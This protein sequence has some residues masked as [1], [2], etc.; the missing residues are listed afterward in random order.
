MK[1][2]DFLKAGLASVSLAGCNSNWADSPIHQ[3][4]GIAPTVVPMYRL[5]Y[6]SKSKHL[7][8]GSE[9]EYNVLAS[10]GWRREN[11]SFY[12]YNNP[13]TVENQATVAWYRLYN[14]Y[15]GRHHWTTSLTEYEILGTIGWKQEG[16]TAYMLTAQ[17]SNS[18]P[19]FRLYNPNN[20]AHHWT[21]DT[22]EKDVLVSLGWKDEGIIGYVFAAAPDTKARPNILFVYTDDQRSDSLG[23]MG[24]STIQTP[25]LDDYASKGT[26]FNNSYITSS[27]CAISRACS[28]T[29]QYASKHGVDDFHKT[30]SDSQLDNS[31]PQI[32]R[33]NGYYVGFIGKWGI[34]DSITKTATAARVFDYWGGFSHQGSYWH[35]ADCRYVNHDGITDKTNNTC[36]C[37]ADSRGETGPRN[38]IG[39][40]NLVDPIHL[41]TDV[42]PAKVSD[43]LTTRN[44]DQPFCLNLYMKGPHSP[45]TDIPP[46]MESLY[47]GDVPIARTASPEF[48]DNLPSFIDNALGRSTG[49][50]YARNHD[51]L[52]DF[53]R[54]YYRQVTSID[55]AI[56]NIKALLELHGVA[57][58]TIVMLNSDNGHLHGEKGFAGKW[59]MYEPSVRVPGLIYDPRNPTQQRKDESILNIDFPATILDYAGVAVPENFQGVSMKPLVE[60]TNTGWRDNWFYEMPYGHFGNITIPKSYGITRGTLKYTNYYENNSYEELFDISTDPEEL[61]NLALV[62]GHEDTLVAFRQ[63][64]LQ[65]KSSIQNG[66]KAI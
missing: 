37:P 2:R 34:G 32:L 64:A 1:R 6:P 43:F 15:S 41:T 47:L 7:Y 36:D 40:A 31:F 48:T 25:I 46:D 24:N 33:D 9:H 54:N 50:Y 10:L 45:H 35:E 16:V 60:N 39:K 17:V 66:G 30:L 42:I 49:K 8:T 20:G 4:E 26:V 58:N 13:T 63:L 27:V 11:I 12:V 55:T 29:S 5:F 52:K 51:A 53:V 3:A 19:L 56:G 23:F 57:E 38:R 62:A 21:L 65:Y 61:T 18:V 59:F 22:N 28:M 44:K 14:R